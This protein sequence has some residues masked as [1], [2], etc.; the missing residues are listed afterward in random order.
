MNSSDQ[1][2]ARLLAQSRETV[3]D[4]GAFQLERRPW[5]HPEQPPSDTDLVRFALWACRDAETVDPSVLEAALRLLSSA[6]AEFDQVEAGMFFMARS[7]GLT[8]VQI[9]AALELG[10][11]QAAQQRFDRLLD[12]VRGREAEA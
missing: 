8:W 3:K 10:S 5:E 6:R 11:A 9:A 4:A 7:S 2:R 12:R 1:E